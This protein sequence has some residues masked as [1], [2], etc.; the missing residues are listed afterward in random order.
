MPYNE[1]LALLDQREYYRRQTDRN[2]FHVNELCRWNRDHFELIHMPS[3]NMIQEIRSRIQNQA[4]EE[5][6]LQ[7]M[8][9]IQA[10]DREMRKQ[11]SLET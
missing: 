6:F 5:L 4:E 1:D 9:R 3:D 11:F 7:D 10:I 8:E 2:L